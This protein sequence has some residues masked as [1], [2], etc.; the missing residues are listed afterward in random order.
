VSRTRQHVLSD[1]DRVLAQLALHF[2]NRADECRKAAA[3]VNKLHPDYAALQGK[4]TGFD[5]A[6]AATLRRQ[7][8]VEE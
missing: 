3:S 1:T 5:E 7:S 8:G 2:L 6:W 4:A